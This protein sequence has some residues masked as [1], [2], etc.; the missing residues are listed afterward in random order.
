[1]LQVPDVI[2]EA[3]WLNEN[4]E[5]SN[6]IILDATMKKVTNA[7]EVDLNQQQIKNA[8]FFDLKNVFCVQKAEFPN[9]VLDADTFQN[10]A[11]KLGINQ[12][13]CIVVY[14]DLGIYSSP[15]VWWLFKLMGFQNIAVL[16]GGFPVWK[17]NSFPL[18]SK[19]NPI[20][21]KGNFISKRQPN[22][23]IK[24]EEILNSLSDTTTKVVDARSH[25]RFIGIDPEPRKGLP[26][27]RI[28]G[29]SNIPYVKVLNNFTI[30]SKVDLEVILKP[31]ESESRVV[32]SCGSGITASILALAFSYVKNRN[33]AVYDGSWTEWGS[34][35]ST[36]KE[37]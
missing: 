25:N 21:K 18:E 5:N 37:I 13:S 36:P 1:M 30:K 14:D 32:F 28:P 16:N 3:D 19:K 15:R 2:V 23:S 4:L 12:E 24:K 35:E 17:T 20:L 34:D 33:Y 26:S 31:Y 29:S 9:T 6:L 22:L 8:I 10:E 11:Q 27:G 7:S